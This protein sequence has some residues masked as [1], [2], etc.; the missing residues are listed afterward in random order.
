M[1]TNEK[2]SVRRKKKTELPQKEEILRRVR[3]SLND[4]C[5]DMK[6]AMKERKRQ[7]KLLHQVDPAAQKS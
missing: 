4:A 2:P 7:N 6:E 1:N 3:V 5:G